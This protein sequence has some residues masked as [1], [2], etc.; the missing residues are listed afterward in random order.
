[1]IHYPGITADERIRPFGF[2]FG[3]PW[4]G[5]GFGRPFGFWGPGPFIGGL[6]GG[7]V[8]SALLAPYY[9]YPPYP[10]PYYY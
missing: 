10:Y 8:G 7:L 6:V 5:Y 3:R 2:G 1:M 9:W 4:F